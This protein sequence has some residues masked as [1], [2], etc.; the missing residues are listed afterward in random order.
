MK[1][2]L[3]FLP[4][5]AIGH[6]VGMVEMAKLF[7]SRHE[8]LS[9]TVFISKFYMDT[10]VDNYNKSLLTNPT[11]R[12]TIVNLPETDPQ[13]YMLKPRHAILPSVI[14]TQKTHVR[15]IISGM[16]QSESTRVVGL[17]ADLL[18]INIMDIANEFNVPIYVYS[19]AG[20][21]YLGLAFHLQTLYDKKQ[22]V[23]EFRN[24]DTELLVPGFANPVPAEVLPS[25]YVDKEG[26]YDYLFSLFRRCRESKAI[27]I[28]TFEELEPYAINS[29]RMDS[30]IPPIYPVG[31][32]LNL[33]GDGQNSDEAAVIL[34]WLDDQPPSSVVFLCF[35]SYGT[36][37]ENQVKEIAMGLERS[38]HR[39]LWA[40]R[41]SIPKGETK[42]QLKYSNL[43]E[44]L[45]VGFLDRTSCVGKV[46]GWAPQVAVLGHEAVAGFMSH[47]GWNS[48]L[49]SVWFGVPVAT[50][51]MYG[52]Q[53]LNAF[54]M[55]KELGL[56]V[57]IEVDYKN[58]YFNTKNDFIVRAEEIETK[59]KKLMMDEKNS[60]IRKKVKEM[61]E[62]SRVAM[63]ENGSSYNS[64]AKLFEEIM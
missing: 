16:T 57:E 37:Q 9:V 24:S 12:L 25:M 28:N 22:D 30:M 61:K 23:T 32:I 45:P 6:L 31:P 15:D 21:G 48:T 43:E 34:G 27:I 53:H 35:G 29:L 40:L 54:E 64:L 44:I 63:S 42:L 62:K 11:P 13:N 14:E 58:E 17:L 59:I 56:A 47:C 3:I 4:A 5:P 46:I 20:A 2:E 1:S 33:N 19:P 52:E 51:P 26:G 7:I 8:N 50:W 55:V 41:P 60:E 39:F 18:F 10:G 38:G 49:E 36:F